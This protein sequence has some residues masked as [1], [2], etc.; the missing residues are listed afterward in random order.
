MDT[1]SKQ[2]EKQHGKQC[3]RNVPPGG[4]PRCRGRRRRVRY[5]PHAS[6]RLGYNRDKADHVRYNRYEGGRVRYNQYGSQYGSDGYGTT[7]RATGPNSGN[8]YGGGASW[9]S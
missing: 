5:G 1:I 4:G 7:G 6:G 3:E 2:Y 9:E 8:D